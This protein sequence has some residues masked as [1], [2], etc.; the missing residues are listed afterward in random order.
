MKNWHQ[1]RLAS[2]LDQ[3]IFDS[4]TD[5]KGHEIIVVSDVFPLE[6]K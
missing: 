4:E 3:P 6:Q 2:R 5:K 1:D